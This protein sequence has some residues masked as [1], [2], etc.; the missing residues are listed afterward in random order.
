MTSSES[1]AR[2]VSVE[3]FD[4]DTLTSAAIACVEQ[5]SQGRPFAQAHSITL[6]FHPDA[7]FE[8]Q[9]VLSKIIEDGV[10]RS[11]FETAI[12]GGSVSYHSGGRRWQW[13]SDLF[14]GTYDKAPSMLRPKY[15]ALNFNNSPVGAAPRF[16]S[17]HI[18]LKPCVSRKCTFAYPD[19]NFSP[20]HFGTYSRMDLI[21]LA[22]ANNAVLD[23][24]DDY[25]EA[26]VHGQ[27]LLC[28]DVACVV[29]DPSFRNT[30]IEMSAR[31]LPVELRWHDGFCLTSEYYDQCLAYRGKDVADCIEQLSEQGKLTP[32]Q[33]SPYRD[34][35]M[36]A[37][38]VKKLWH[39]LARFGELGAAHSM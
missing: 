11:Q 16:G 33:L 29:L 23:K 8:G 12:S 4:A 39:C 19:S 10:Y 22:V 13:E 17:A 18:Q 5:K 21:P 32:A 35:S 24:L 27:L 2:T 1:S 31:E 7:L 3:K 9:S 15:G 14:D 26:H 37:Q 34:G 36:D 6:N 20:V 38:L 30:A 28:R 25:I